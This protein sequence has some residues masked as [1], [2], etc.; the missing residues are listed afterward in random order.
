[1]IAVGRNRKVNRYTILIVDD[2]EE[3]KTHLITTFQDAGFR[4]LTASGAREA[5]L[6]I[7]SEKPAFL[8]MDPDSRSTDGMEL[9]ENL[10]KT[11]PPFA[12]IIVILTHRGDVDSKLQFLAQGAHEVLLKPVDAREVTARV[13]RFIRMIAEF[14]AIPT[15]SQGANKLQVPPSEA[16][17]SQGTVDVVAPNLTPSPASGRSMAPTGWSSLPVAAAWATYSKLTKNRSTVLWL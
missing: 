15:S 3:Q 2:A 5:I 13:L 1:M 4:T 14:R 12:L 16:D 11:P 7:H 8:I 17:R 6:R 9:L 10:Q